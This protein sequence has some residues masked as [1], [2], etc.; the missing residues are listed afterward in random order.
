MILGYVKGRVLISEE[1]IREKVKELGAQISRDYK[2]KK[3]IFVC[4]LK[5]AAVFYTDLLREISED[6]DV[7]FDFL[8]ISSYGAS[9]KSSGVV[10]IQKDLSTDI[11]DTNV[12]IVEDILDTGLTLAYIKNLLNDRSPKSLEVCVL[13]DKKERRLTPVDAKYTGFVI[14]DEFIIGY[15]LDCAEQFRNLRSVYVAEQEE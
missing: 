6:V 9:T 5:G 2:G 11:Q 13:F 12:I 15:G 4:V 7:R 1:E 10:K 3:V 14:P 8:A